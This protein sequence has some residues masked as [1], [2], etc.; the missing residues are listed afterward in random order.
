MI[1]NDPAGAARALASELPPEEGEAVIRSFAKHSARS[2]GDPLTYAGYM[3][4]P[5]S[6]LFCEEDTAGPPKFQ[7]A[8]ID[9]VERVSG[10][11]IEVTKIKAGHMMNFRNERDL[12]EF[13]VSRARKAEGKGD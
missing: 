11:K 12:I 5:A 8:W 10:R 3:D 1:L 4:I 9:A 13:L 6:F 7:Q 2:F